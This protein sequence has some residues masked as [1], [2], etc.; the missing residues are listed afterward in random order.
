[1]KRAVLVLA[2]LWVVIPLAWGVYESVQK[3]LPLFLD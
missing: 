2:W 3:S 1:M